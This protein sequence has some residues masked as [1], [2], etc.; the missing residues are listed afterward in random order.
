MTP[1][2]D[3]RGKPRSDALDKDRVWEDLYRRF[4]AFEGSW[5]P[6][7]QYP[8]DNRLRTQVMSALRGERAVSR[9]PEIDERAWVTLVELGRECHDLLDDADSRNAIGTAADL[10]LDGCYHLAVWLLTAHASWQQRP[11][12]HS[13]PMRSSST[14]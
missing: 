5:A 12:P 7:G 14:P 9:P 3:T 11:P 4:R 10:P 8:P 6:G 13:P 2:N 1:T